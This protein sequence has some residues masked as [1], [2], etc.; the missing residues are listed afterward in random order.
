MHQYSQGKPTTQAHKGI[1]EGHF[2]EE[3]G[4][5]GFFGPVSHLIR[6]KPSTRWVNIEG[7]LRPRMFDLVNLKEELGLQRLLFNSDIHIYMK[8]TWMDL[9]F[10][11]QIKPSRNR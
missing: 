3:Q 6:R 1:P 7:P 8:W 10:E 4:L 2:E 5:Q 9:C 11:K